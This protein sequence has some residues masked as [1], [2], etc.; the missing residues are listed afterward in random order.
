MVAGLEW[1]RDQERETRR[2]ER[3]EQREALEAATRDASG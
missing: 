2:L 3:T 1:W